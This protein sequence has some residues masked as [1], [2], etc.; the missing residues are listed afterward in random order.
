M[1][2][3]GAVSAFSRASSVAAINPAVGFCWS[4]A[5]SSSVSPTAVNLRRTASS[6][7]C[8]A[9]SAACAAVGVTCSSSAAYWSETSEPCLLASSMMVRTSAGFLVSA[10]RQAASKIARSAASGKSYAAASGRTAVKHAGSMRMEPMT[11]CAAKLMFAPPYKPR[12]ACKSRP[13]PESKLIGLPNLDGLAASYLLV[14]RP[15]PSAWA[16]RLPSAVDSTKSKRMGCTA[17]R[18]ASTGHSASASPK[19]SRAFP[20]G[21]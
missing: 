15:L 13:R 6:W 4:C 11:L 5:S 16:P 19:R 21:Q 8:R 2:I 12:A 20:V 18:H 1:V 14:L 7:T 9:Y 10:N 17:H 3:C